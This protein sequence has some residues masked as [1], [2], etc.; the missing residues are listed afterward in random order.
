MFKFILNVIFILFTAPVMLSA[1]EPIII[2]NS[3]KVVSLPKYAEVLEDKTNSL[4]INDILTEKIS[5]SFSAFSKDRINFG[6]SGSTFWIRYTCFNNLKNDIEYYVKIDNPM[7]DYIMFYQPQDIGFKTTPMGDRLPFNSREIKDRNFIIPVIQKPGSSTFYISIRSRSNLV[8]PINIF[9]SRALISDVDTETIPLSIIFGIMIIM[10]LYNLFLFV[11]LREQA[12]IYYV[13][14]ILFFVLYRMTAHGFGFQYFWPEN[15]WIQNYCSTAFVGLTNA[16]LLFFNRSFLDLKKYSTKLDKISQV[17]IAAL[18]ICITLFLSGINQV[19]YFISSYF[20]FAGSAVSI[21]SGI[22]CYIRGCRLARLYM[23]SW[24]FFLIAVIIFLL[25]NYNLIQ[26]GFIADWSIYIGMVFIAVFFSL[27]LADKVN[28]ISNENKKL[29]AE[30]KAANEKL[31]IEMDERISAEKTVLQQN[32]EIQAQ[33]EEIQ[34][35]YEEIQAQYEE[36]DS[37]NTELMHSQNELLDINK[38]LNDE[39]EQLSTMLLS[40]GDGVIATDSNGNIGLMNSVAEKMTGYNSAE[41]IGKNINEIFIILNGTTKEKVENPVFTVLRKKETSGLSKNAIIISPELKE[42]SITV[43]AAPMFDN[44]KNISGTILVFRD[45]TEMLLM[46]NEFQKSRTIESIGLLAGGIAHDFNNILTAI[47]ANVSLAKISIEDKDKDKVV[48]Y[49]NESEKAVLRARDLT[50]QLLTFAKGGAPLKKLSSIKDILKDSISFALTGSNIKSEFSGSDD[51]RDAEIDEGQ[52]S[53]VLYNLII[54]AKQSMANGGVINVSADNIILEDN[55]FLNLKSGIYLKI[56]IK[57]QGEGISQE[58]I[59]KIF[60]PYFTTKT[61]GTGLGLTSSY[62]IIKKHNGTIDVK[63][64]PGI[65]STFTVYLPSSE[66][67]V[68]Q[69]KTD[70]S[71]KGKNSGRILIMDDESSIVKASVNMLT[72]LGYE[73]DSSTTGEEAVEKYRI[74][75]EQN[76][77]Y[78]IVIMDLTVP[79]GMGGEKLQIKLMEIDPHVKSIVSSGYSN[80]PVMSQYTEYGFRGIINKPYSI[81]NLNSVIEAVLKQ[82]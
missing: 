2:D 73:V 39:K 4:A 35:Q 30:V 65:G 16:G 40:I 11:S 52:I 75:F 8:L 62:S 43:S 37:L 24:S 44:N 26:S 41:T 45:I 9:S 10:M 53:Q 66:M 31:E 59:D 76:K 20:V 67:K 34:A 82:A 68:V 42:R 14:F 29:Y 78:D 33:Y 46:E 6:Y 61:V 80:D 5:K 57:D 60:N 27:A 69:V 3:L 22:V 71:I 47:L 54:N 15:I 13:S 56:S 18:L 32:E 50:Q 64:E 77:K 1:S 25:R 55:N 23:V 36:M 48:E 17:L 19:G 79:G 12:Y 21:A 7:I 63:S 72:F 70:D 74:A 28:I 51:L 49:M 58:N 81:Q 38:E